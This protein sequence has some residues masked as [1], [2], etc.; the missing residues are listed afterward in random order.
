MN[1]GGLEG[2]A[3]AL[4]VVTIYAEH[5]YSFLLILDLKNKQ[6]NCADPAK[7]G[8]FLNSKAVIPKVLYGF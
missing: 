2:V 1:V 5:R 8:K 6:T 4:A 7:T 3:A